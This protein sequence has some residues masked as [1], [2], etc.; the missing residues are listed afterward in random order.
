MKIHTTG[1]ELF[2]ADGQIKRWTNGRT[3]RQTRHDE[4]NLAFRY[5]AEGLK[6]NL[7]HTT[8]SKQFKIHRTPVCT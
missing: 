4:A 2:H 5:F 6:K 7:L 8:I 1:V 3:V